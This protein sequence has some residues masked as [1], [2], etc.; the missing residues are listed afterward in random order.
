M[1]IYDFSRPTWNGW[2]GWKLIALASSAVVL[3]T[4]VGVETQGTAPIPSSSAGAK[5]ADP[6]YQGFGAKTPGGSGKPIVR[7]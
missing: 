4:S 2:T 3:A 7:V 1:Q 6:A 5:T